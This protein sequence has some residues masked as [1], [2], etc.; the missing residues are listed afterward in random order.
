MLVEG[1]KGTCTGSGDPGKWRLGT[2]TAYYPPS[3][4][5]ALALWKRE[6]EREVETDGKWLKR[7]F[8]RELLPIRFALAVYRLHHATNWV[9]GRSWRAAR[10]RGNKR[11]RPLVELVRLA[12]RWV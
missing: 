12:P 2:C 10:E 3:I 1:Q 11:K 8:L 5:R 4:R 9:T 7:C 6:R